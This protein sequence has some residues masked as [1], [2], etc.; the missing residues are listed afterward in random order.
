MP[1]TVIF[2]D[3][4]HLRKIFDSEG[5]RCDVPKCVK[6]ILELAKINEEDL[7][8]VYYYTSPPYQSAKPTFDEKQRYAAF[9][10]F[11]AFL[12][13]QDNFEIKLGRTEK[14][15]NDF[16]QKMVDV[17]LSIDLVELS[18]RSRIGTAIL[19]TGDSDLVPAVKKAKDNGVRV[20]LCCSGNKWQYHKNLWNEADRRIVMDQPF[21]N[22]CCYNPPLP[23]RP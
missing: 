3:G 16:E 7:L 20:I 6:K 18:A 19:V 2:I 14:R 13:T 9:Q 23:P 4:E 10:K 12:K 21:M 15:G 11:E 1:S 17:L 22:E 5:F 8:R